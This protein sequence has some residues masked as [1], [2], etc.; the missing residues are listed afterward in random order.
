MYAYA[1]TSILVE[2]MWQWATTITYE[3]ENGNIVAEASGE[4]FVDSE[5]DALIG[6]GAGYVEGFDEARCEVNGV[7]SWQPFE[8]AGSYQV[9]VTGEVSERP[10]NAP[11]TIKFAPVGFDTV[12]DTTYRTSSDC[13]EA[14]TYRNDFVGSLGVGLLVERPHWLNNAPS[15]FLTYIQP[16][17]DPITFEE[18]LA[19]VPG[20]S[21][22]GAISKPQP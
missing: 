10:E 6:A 14:G 9:M 5:F 17:G 1:E 2:A 12:V 11:W 22:Q 13:F 15:G 4:F 16:A 21:I 20:A 8:V 7:V 18:T 19:G 3:D